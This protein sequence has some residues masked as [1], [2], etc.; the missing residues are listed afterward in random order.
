M[1]FPPRGYLNPH[2]MQNKLICQSS[3]CLMRRLACC[4]DPHGGVI[5]RNY[6][7]NSPFSDTVEINSICLNGPARRRAE[8]LQISFLLVG[9]FNP[10]SLADEIVGKFPQRIV[11]GIAEARDSQ[12][13]IG[14]NKSAELIAIPSQ[15]DPVGR[16]HATVEI[17]WIDD[18]AFHYFTLSR[19]SRGHGRPLTRF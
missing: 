17:T 10:Y 1:P 16:Q 4:A 3:Q 12:N 13:E 9:H 6:S 11:D 5:R 2:A 19:L 8:R 7:P 15:L 18:I 14:A